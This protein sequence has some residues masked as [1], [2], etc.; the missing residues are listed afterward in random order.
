MVGLALVLELE[1]ELELELQSNLRS[2][3]LMPASEQVV[4]GRH[5]KLLIVQWLQE[6]CRSIVESGR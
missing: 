3:P 4:V 6:S 5:S 2:Q 1:P